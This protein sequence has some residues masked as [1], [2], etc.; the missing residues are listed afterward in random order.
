[1]KTKTELM[2]TPEQMI[3]ALMEAARSAGMDAREAYR[4]MEARLAEFQPAE[5][6][7]LKRFSQMQPRHLTP[8]EVR[9]I[10]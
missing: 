4:R 3:A 7:R 5:V 8:D 1:M 6:S 10:L 9:L 2:T